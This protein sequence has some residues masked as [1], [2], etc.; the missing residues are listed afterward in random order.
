MFFFCKKTEIEKNEALKS[1]KM[2][3]REKEEIGKK[4]SG[5]EEKFSFLGQ[6]RIKRKSTFF[7]FLD[8][9]SLS[10]S[11]DSLLGGS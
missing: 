3:N 11:L 2:K 5:K 6:K 8:F 9:L 10:L 7:L 4:R 1:K